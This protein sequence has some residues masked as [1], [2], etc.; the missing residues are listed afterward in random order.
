MKLLNVEV[1]NDLVGKH[2]TLKVYTS[3]NKKGEIRKNFN[4]GAIQNQEF[5]QFNLNFDDVSIPVAEIVS[6]KDNEKCYEVVVRIDGYKNMADLKGAKQTC[7]FF[8]GD[9]SDEWGRSGNEK[10]K[11]AKMKVAAFKKGL[12]GPNKPLYVKETISKKDPSK[13]YG[14]L[15]TKK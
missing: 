3:H 8:Y 5:T 2:T 10:V 4:L 7:V 15:S 14:S 6:E 9:K 13:H 1:E 12:Y 11:S